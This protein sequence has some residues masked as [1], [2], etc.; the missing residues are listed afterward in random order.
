M[1]NTG[2]FP[3]SDASLPFCYNCASRIPEGD[4]YCS[5]CGTPRKARAAPAWASWTASILVKGAVA[6]AAV[7]VV[8]VFVQLWWLI[9]EVKPKSGRAF[10]CSLMTSENRNLI[11]Y[12]ERKAAKDWAKAAIL[13]E[14]VVTG[15]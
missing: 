8:Y 1:K 13:D 10:Y 4:S 11:G 2:Q 12:S 15:D 14:L 7:M 5:N 3:H 9:E 6:L